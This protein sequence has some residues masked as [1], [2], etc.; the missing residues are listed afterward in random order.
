MHILITLLLI[1]C[2]SHGVEVGPPFQGHML[3]G[4]TDIG[5][6]QAVDR[7]IRFIDNPYAKHGPGYNFFM[8][9]DSDHQMYTNG[10]TETYGEYLKIIPLRNSC[11]WA[12]YWQSKS[13]EVPVQIGVM[14]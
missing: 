10:A 12:R 7:G 5:M 9:W 11:L 1:I 8:T 13:L 14:K 2:S 3:Y 6:I 4:D